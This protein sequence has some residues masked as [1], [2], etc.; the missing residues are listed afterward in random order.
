MFEKKQKFSL[1]IDPKENNG[2]ELFFTTIE[3]S[4]DE[5]PWRDEEGQLLI[6]V[7]QT[8][9]EII[10]VATMSG[11]KPENI[12]LHLHNDLLTIRG[13]RESGIP[14]QADHI[15]S[16]TYWGNFSRTVV[17]PKDVKPEFARAEYNYGV[18][19][20]YLPKAREDQGIPIFVI[21]EFQMSALSELILLR[22]RL[23]ILL[24][25]LRLSNK[26][27][28]FVHVLPLVL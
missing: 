10:V 16:E 12:N 6:D 15:L 7:A 2:E 3:K 27:R 28:I 20:I 21:D 13:K 18:L 4:I 25:R 8:K 14:E 9:D 26:L 17:L 22:L 24:I 5:H 19:T 23:L 1:S 11:A